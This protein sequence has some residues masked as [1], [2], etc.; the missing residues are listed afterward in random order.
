MGE[1]D[2]QLTPVAKDLY[3]WVG[4]RLGVLKSQEEANTELPAVPQDWLKAMNHAYTR[5]Q[6]NAIQGWSCRFPSTWDPVAWNA[7][8]ATGPDYAT[9]VPILRWDH[10]KAY[11]PSPDAWKQAKTF[12]NHGAFAEGVELFDP[13][14][15]GL[16]PAE[17]RGMDPC[18]RWCLE[19]GYDALRNAGY[20]KKDV[21]GSFGAVYMACDSFLEWGAVEFQGD[22][23]YATG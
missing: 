20:K 21:S 15:F 8:F 17:A 11:D 9:T 13:K 3:D 10:E 23:N 1:D 18:Q 12:C 14:V 2:L 22:G 5:G 7:A 19:G 16:A 6:R 4:A